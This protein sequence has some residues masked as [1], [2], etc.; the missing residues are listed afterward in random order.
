MMFPILG[1]GMLLLLFVIIKY[2]KAELINL[3]LGLYFA[4]MG[5]ASV[6]RVRPISLASHNMMMMTQLFRM[7]SLFNRRQV[8]LY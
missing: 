3:V 5:V 8:L 6:W 2:L 7:S 1:S 4:A